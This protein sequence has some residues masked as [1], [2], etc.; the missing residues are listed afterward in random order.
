MRCGV[1]PKARHR[2]VCGREPV[3]ERG[4]GAGDEGQDGLAPEDALGFGEVR[5]GVVASCR[6]R[7]LS[8]HAEQHGRHAE[9]QRDLARGTGY[10]FFGISIRS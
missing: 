7:S 6:R 3:R 2:V 5:V 4:G 1:R 10:F 8:E 9:R